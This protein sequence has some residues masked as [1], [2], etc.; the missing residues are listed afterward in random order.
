MFR[1]YRHFP[2]TSIAVPF[3]FSMVPT[4]CDG[5]SVLP[6]PFHEAFGLCQRMI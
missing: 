6:H 5:K 2:A 3:R 4:V 1:A